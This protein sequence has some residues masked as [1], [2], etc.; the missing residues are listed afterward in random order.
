MVYDFACTNTGYLPLERYL[1]LFCK[2]VCTYYQFN[3]IL[4]K[5]K[6]LK[7]INLCHNIIYNT[8]KWLIREC[9]KKKRSRVI[10]DFRIQSCV[11]YS[12]NI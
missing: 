2:R 3:S 5:L 4:F 12:I 7:G 11:K 10:H 8:L 9:S 6:K 1:I